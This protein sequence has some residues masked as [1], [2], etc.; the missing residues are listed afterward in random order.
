MGATA[1]LERVW[2]AVRETLDEFQLGPD[3]P[4]R[5]K[6]KLRP[7]KRPRWM[8]VRDRRIPQKTPKTR[9]PKKTP[10]RPVRVVV[11]RKVRMP[12]MIIERERAVIAQKAPPEPW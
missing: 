8:D 11:K 6:K 5:V 9:I 10:K 7:Q 4:R 2:D 3:R 1:I 12:P